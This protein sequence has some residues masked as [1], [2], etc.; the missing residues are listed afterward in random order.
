[1]ATPITANALVA[2][3]EDEG[4]TVAEVRDWRNHNRNHKGAWGPVHGI[5]IHHTVTSG[6]ERTVDICYDGYAELPGPLCH[7][8]ITKD[9]TVHLV[10]HGRANHAGLGDDDV[11]RAVIAEKGL[12]APNEQNTDGNSRFYGFECENLGDGEDPWPAAQLEA[13]EKASA[14]LCR[15]HGWNAPSV[16]GH[17]EWT[18]QKVDPRGFSMDDM[19]ERIAE[20]LK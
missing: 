8:V 5:M 20:R 10:G 6:A 18:N 19:R 9:G 14:A 16:I 11:L 13:I 4:L 2:A 12:P 1:M 7:G 15:H 3:L 17:K